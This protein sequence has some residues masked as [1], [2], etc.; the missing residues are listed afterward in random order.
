[1]VFFF[2]SPIY[3]LVK[4]QIKHINGLQPYKNSIITHIDLICVI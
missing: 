4:K 2:V 1:M 3:R